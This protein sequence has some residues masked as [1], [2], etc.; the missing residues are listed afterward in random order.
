MN[1][2]EYVESQIETWRQYVVLKRQQDGEISPAR[3]NKALAEYQ[4]VNFALIAEEKRIQIE[5]ADFMLEYNV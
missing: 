1:Y 2:V 4:E 3:L 5:L